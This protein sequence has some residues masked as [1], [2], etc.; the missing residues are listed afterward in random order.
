MV[1]FEF[2]LIKTNSMIYIC[3]IKYG[4]NLACVL[5]VG[6]DELIGE[7]RGRGG[8]L[9]VTYMVVGLWFVVRVYTQHEPTPGCPGS[10]D[11]GGIC[12]EV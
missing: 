3:Y 4:V 12:H 1:I 11:L 8:S 9:R 5:T 2:L 10:W 7:I 6:D